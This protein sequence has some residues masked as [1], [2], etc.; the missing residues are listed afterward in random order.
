VLKL[1][2]AHDKKMKESKETAKGGRQKRTQDE[3]SPSR[4]VSKRGRL[5]RT[6]VVGDSDAKINNDDSNRSRSR[7][8]SKESKFGSF[9]LGDR[10]RSFLDVKKVWE[11]KQLSFLVEWKTRKNG[12]IPRPSWVTEK[13]L[14]KHDIDS[15][16]VYLLS[17][18]KW[19]SR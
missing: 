2:D 19:S 5:N 8:E 16:C 7:S 4:P 6:I 13:D 3:T 9:S 14:R 18:I 10:L 11:L 17:K 15:L 1:I 12:I